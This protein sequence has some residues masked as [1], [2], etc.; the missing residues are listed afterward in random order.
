MKSFDKG[1]KIELL[2]LFMFI[3]NFDSKIVHTS[4][5]F[6][7]HIWNTEITRFDGTA[8]LYVVVVL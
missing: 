8:Q 7:F 4:K 2:K 6:T 1:W 5:L 3:N